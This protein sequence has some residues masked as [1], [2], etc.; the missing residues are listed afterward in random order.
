[1]VEWHVSRDTVVGVTRY[2]R[3]CHVIRSIELGRNRV[4]ILNDWQRKPM[5]KAE[6]KKLA[7]LR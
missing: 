2:S 4:V 7:I 5:R 1:M 3:M 6:I